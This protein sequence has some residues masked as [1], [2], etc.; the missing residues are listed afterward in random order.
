[1]ANSRRRAVLAGVVGL[2]G[3]FLGIAGTGH[4]YLREWRRAVGWFALEIGVIL[5]LVAT[6]VETPPTTVGDLPPVVQAALAVILVGSVIDALM[7]AMRRSQGDEQSGTTAANAE[8]V[9][10]IPGEEE[11]EEVTCPHCGK[12]V[13]PDLDFCHWC[14]EPLPE[15]AGG[16]D[17]ESGNAS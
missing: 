6:V 9:V 2:V 7:V 11:G 3:A 13:D 5:V 17:P 12:N 4:V 15:R 14:T 8:G 16:A 10:P 1:M